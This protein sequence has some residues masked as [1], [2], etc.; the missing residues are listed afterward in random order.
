MDPKLLWQR[1]DT[2]SRISARFF[3][4]RLSLRV[5]ALLSICV[6]LYNVVYS[7]ELRR[8]LEMNVQAPRHTGQPQH[9]TDT[10]ELEDGPP[11]ATCFGAELGHNG[12][13]KA[14]LVML[15]RN[16]ELHGALSSIRMVE[17]RF[18]RRFHYP[19]TFL[20]DKPFTDDFIKYTS[21]LA[22]GPVEY[23]VIP[24][25]DWSIPDH[26]NTTIMRAEMLRMAK[27]EIIYGG[28]LSYRHMCRFNSGFFYN[29]EVM[30]KYDWY[31]RVEPGIELYCDINYD[32]FTFMRENKKIYGFV[33]SMYEFRDTITTL[34][35][36]TRQFLNHGDYNLCHFWSNFEIASLEFY[37]SEAYSRYFEFLDS[38]G[39][40]FYERWGDAP[41]HSIGVGLFAPKDSIHH[42]ADFGYSHPPCAR[43]P[44][45]DESHT[46][47]RCVCSRNKNFDSDSYSCLPRWW[48][49]N[50]GTG[51]I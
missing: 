34:W 29:Q 31:W 26:V 36:R 2:G 23:A 25:D 12:T 30:R 39:G 46:S 33:I 10:A 11:S 47:G 17:D 3:T 40:F 24:E 18:N 50:R 16:S 42:F 44:Q 13:E 41:V 43:C 37:R 5:L 7:T 14:T 32:P 45:D 35:D 51:W 27:Q 1:A 20:N 21:G 49:V 22:S 19:W 15:V 6:V 28:S 48:K 4:R 38:T 9:G 8:R